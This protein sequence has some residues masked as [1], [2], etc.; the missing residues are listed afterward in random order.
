MYY[1]VLPFTRYHPPQTSIHSCV[2]P[3]A[4]IP[5]TTKTLSVGVGFAGASLALGAVCNSGDDVQTYGM[6]NFDMFS[7]KFRLR[8]L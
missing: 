2:I 8:P 4:A 7:D 6:R 3:Q 5:K 1:C